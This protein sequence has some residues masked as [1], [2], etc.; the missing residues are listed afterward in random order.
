MLWR[1]ARRERIV[2]FVYPVLGSAFNNRFRAIV[3]TYSTPA[4]CKLLASNMTHNTYCRCAQ[5]YALRA[6]TLGVSRARGVLV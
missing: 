2:P 1:T 3:F 5:M 6:Q 4:A